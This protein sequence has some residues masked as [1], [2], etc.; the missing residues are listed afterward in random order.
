MS[1]LKRLL[2]M[3]LL[4]PMCVLG[5]GG[6][7]APEGAGDS[8]NPDEGNST[9]P[10]DGAGAKEPE[11]T[12]TQK[13]VNRMMK[14]EKE[15]GKRALLKEMGFT[16]A[17]SAEEG[18]KAYKAYI[19]SQK[20]ELQRAQ[21]AA[22]SADTAKKEA[23]NRAAVAEACFAAVQKGVKSEYAKDLVA[24]ALTKVTE[25]APLDTVLEEM[26]KSPAY[27]GF[28]GNTDSQK[29]QQGT[30]KPIG[31]GKKSAEGGETNYGKELAKRLKAH[32][33][34]PKES[35]YFKK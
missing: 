29:K 3:T 2:K 35:P 28:F 1:K 6:G 27:S 11:K 13:D 16:D 4:M 23:E 21:E 20:T 5:I 12:F 14:A 24:I 9:P 32:Q 19:D 34:P 18:I 31:Q 10:D 22:S 8:G 30:G 33:A 26:Q 7:S 25:Y 15:S 17:T